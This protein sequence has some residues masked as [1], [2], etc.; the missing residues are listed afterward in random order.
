MA[1]NG[2][3]NTGPTPSR[4]PHEQQKQEEEEEEVVFEPDEEFM[5]RQSSSAT[6]QTPA[7]ASSASGA[8]VSSSTKSVG[9]VETAGEEES[10]VERFSRLHTKYDFIKVKVWLEDHYYILSRFIVSRMLTLIKVGTSQTN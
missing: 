3:G 7:P 1:S 5:A 6:A 9:F 8:L 4:P 10:K 2:V